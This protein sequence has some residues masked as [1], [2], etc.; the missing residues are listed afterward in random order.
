MLSKDIAARECE[1]PLQEL[2]KIFHAPDNEV[3]T[4]PLQR[5]EIE[6]LLAR[7]RFDGETGIGLAFPNGD[8]TVRFATNRSAAACG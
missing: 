4:L 3:E 1:Q 6:P 8:R 5:D 2:L 7:Y